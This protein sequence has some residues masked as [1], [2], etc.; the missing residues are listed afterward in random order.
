M[1]AQFGGEV[2]S[3]MLLSS[4]FHLYKVILFQAMNDINVS[5]A[6]E[7][8]EKDAELKT[9]REEIEKLKQAQPGVERE[10]SLIKLIFSPLC[11][12]VKY[13][14]RFSRSSSSCCQN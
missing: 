6:L 4:Y 7:M 13:V 5:L 3:Q 14:C 10:F 11:D 9:L 2:L 12:K 1:T 8:S